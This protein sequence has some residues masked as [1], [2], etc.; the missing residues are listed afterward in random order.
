MA[1]KNTVFGQVRDEFG[2]IQLVDDI[3]DGKI[4]DIKST[5][6]SVDNQNFKEGLIA[7]FQNNATILHHVFESGNAQIIK[8][9]LNRIK[10]AEITDTDFQSYLEKQSD[11]GTTAVDQLV[12]GQDIDKLKT[13]FQSMRDTGNEN[14]IQPIVES[15]KNT[16]EVSIAQLGENAVEDLALKQDFYAEVYQAI[17]QTESWADYIQGHSFNGYLKDQL[18]YQESTENM[19]KLLN[20]T[21]ID[22]DTINMLEGKHSYGNATN[23]ASWVGLVGVAGIGLIGKAVKNT[24]KKDMPVE[25]LKEEV[26]EEQ[27]VVVQNQQNEVQVENQQI[28]EQQIVEVQEQVVDGGKQIK[29]V[30]NKNKIES[31]I[32][33][34]L[35]NIK[36]HDEQKTGKH[37]KTLNEWI[38]RNNKNIEDIN[39]KIQSL[40]PENNN[41]EQNN[42]KIQELKQ[43]LKKYEEVLPQ[44][45]NA[46]KWKTYKKDYKN[47][48]QDEIDGLLVEHYLKNNYQVPYNAVKDKIKE[49]NQEIKVVQTELEQ[50]E[51]NQNEVDRLKQLIKEKNKKNEEVQKLKKDLELQKSIDNPPQVQEEEVQGQNQQLQIIEGFQEITFSKEKMNNYYL[52]IQL[53]RE[54]TFYVSWEVL[55]KNLQINYENESFSV[56][57]SQDIV[58]ALRN[59]GIEEVEGLLN[60]FLKQQQ[61]QIQEEVKEE[62]KQEEK[63]QVVQE[64]EQEE[65]GQVKEVVKQIIALEIED[66]SHKQSSEKSCLIFGDSAQNQEEGMFIVDAEKKLEE[67]SNN[68][69]N[70]I[71]Q[72]APAVRE[73]IYD[74]LSTGDQKPGETNCGA[75]CLA[76]IQELR[77]QNPQSIYGIQYVSINN[78]KHGQVFK[79]QPEIPRSLT[80]NSASFP[81]EIKLSFDAVQAFGT[82]QLNKPA[83]QDAPSL[84][85]SLLQPRWETNPDEPYLIPFKGKGAD[86]E[87]QGFYEKVANFFKG[88]SEIEGYKQGI[89]DILSEH[90]LLDQFKENLASCKNKEELHTLFKRLALKAHPDKGGNEELFKKINDWKQQMNS[91]ADH[92]NVEYESFLK[93]L[94]GL[95]IAFRSGQVMVDIKDVYDDPSTNTAAKL[96]IDSV[97]LYNSLSKYFDWEKIPG[98]EYFGQTM[99][100]Y[101]F[102]SL[103][104]EEEY[105]KATESG[106]LIIGSSIHPLYGLVNFGFDVLLEGEKYITN[107]ICE[108]DALLDC[109]FDL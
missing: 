44:I 11:A 13:V 2:D 77:V 50:E 35:E 16:D 69:H 17:T 30:K 51:Q 92:A 45:S 57:I 87:D 96:G 90:G 42:R 49:L 60:Q 94:E 37:L 22:A 72:I 32:N 91:K 56:Y 80:D 46:N 25:E 58:N 53:S 107:S 85:Y 20:A 66:S 102:G 103:V 64:Q 27:E 36:T 31:K 6:D 24:R 106:M 7:Q 38:E 108:K 81:Y 54:K 4:D 48:G 3:N 100:V 12:Y 61:L 82:Q 55:L 104:D 9:F 43:E 33:K 84:P 97:Y 52:S 65:V 67:L 5:L 18:W 34:Y 98:V 101:R 40:N 109:L 70:I 47:T 88:A 76:K 83:L 41:I 23:T 71:P 8:L 10:D 14:L 89:S 95:D 75:L 21:A 99:Q 79:Y 59:I 93:I 28:A 105:V 15:V 86:K 1:E 68:T 62:V 63:L 78:K 74:P 26:Q 39:K 19:Q 73:A 29:N